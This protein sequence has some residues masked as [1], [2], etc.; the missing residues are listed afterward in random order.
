MATT[1]DG[2][3]TARG[4]ATR[5]RIL[6]ATAGLLGAGARSVTVS[7]VARAAGV[8]PNQITHH[9]G[10]KDR[11]VL[12]AAFA[13]FLR[14]TTRLQA[15]GRRA[16]SAESFRQV[17]ART[18]LAMPSTPLVVRA[19]GAAGDDPAQRER[20]RLLLAVLFRQSER[21]LERV[22]ADQGW[23]SPSGVA[24]DA[25]TFWSAVF[26]ATLLADA[27]VTGGPSDLDLAGTISI[28]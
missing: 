4:A 5:A 7:E 3:G 13:L 20:V 9:Y 21:Y 2:S 1:V 27:G 26:G 28:R 16:R 12:D 19:L 17:L 22:V 23:T 25:R 24:R 8:Y 14:D 11:L 18:A 15:A 10:S 6:A